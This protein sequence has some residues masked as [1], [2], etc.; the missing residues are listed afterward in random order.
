[1]KST[2]GI[3]VGDPT[4]HPSTCPAGQAIMRRVAPPLRC[5]GGPQTWQRRS[6]TTAIPA[7][8]ASAAV[9]ALGW[10]YLLGAFSTSIEVT[11]CAHAAGVAAVIV[12][13]CG[14]DAD[15]HL[16]LDLR[17]D[18]VEATLMDS[19][20]AHVTARDVELARAVTTAIAEL[21]LAAG[22]V[23]TAIERAGRPVQALEVAIDALESPRSVRSGERS[24]RTSTS[25]A[26][27]ARPTRSSTGFARAR[28]SGSSRWT[29]PGR[30]A[31]GSTST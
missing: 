12:D 31:T 5:A 24:W 19:A 13:A 23:A 8:A 21:G 15:R 18:R 20:T 25:P 17:C 29:R 6:M 26:E 1:V 27:A 28:R 3:T 4:A 14:G 7:P 16:R 10:R 9:E 11:S 2:T 22:G 30:S